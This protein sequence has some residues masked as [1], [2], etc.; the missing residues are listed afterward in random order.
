[1]WG[2]THREF[3]SPPLRLRFAES[4]LQRD[5]STVGTRKRH[6]K[7]PKGR[8]LISKP[9][10]GGARER[11]TKLVYTRDMITKK[12]SIA[13]E[14][15]I[16]LM[17]FGAAAYFYPFFP[18]RMASHWGAGGQVN[19]YM[20]R[21]WGVF[22]GPMIGLFLFLL[23]LAIPKMDPKRSNIESF[24]EYYDGLVMTI[25]LFFSYVYLLTLY[26]NL[27][28]SFQFIRWLSP[29]MGVLFFYI[30]YMSPHL[31]SNWTI[32]IRTPWTLSNEAVWEK[33][34]QMAGKWFKIAG[35]LCCMGI[36]FPAQAIW[37]ILVPI[38]AAALGS[39]AYS[40]F[41]HKKLES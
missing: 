14:I 5:E 20:P 41:V 12:K 35:I 34:H 30:G 4:S 22:W 6:L 3:E 29:A 8:F 7:P 9:S 32:G 38:L 13:L 10:V 24:R 11:I 18:E 15:C 31:K 39:V 36:V 2:K 26:W 40:Y 19:A 23:F 33:T 27:G 17:M 28:V 37:F 1:M 16:L 21:T 25:L